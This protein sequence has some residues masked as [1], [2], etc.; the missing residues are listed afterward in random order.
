MNTFQTIIQ[1]VIPKETSSQSENKS[2]MKRKSASVCHGRVAWACGM[3]VWHGRVAWAC[4]MGVCHG[5][6]PWTDSVHLCIL[7]SSSPVL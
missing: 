4:G 5:R 2:T 6:V 7:H 1:T 3:G